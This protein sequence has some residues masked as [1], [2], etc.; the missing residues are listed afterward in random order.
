VVGSRG[1][2]SFSSVLGNPHLA[3]FTFWYEFKRHLGAYPHV[4]GNLAVG[5]ATE[6]MFCDGLSGTNF[7]RTIT[8]LDR[9]PYFAR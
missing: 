6:S 9:F 5:F 7:I 3:R 2:H 8:N 4:D 1:K